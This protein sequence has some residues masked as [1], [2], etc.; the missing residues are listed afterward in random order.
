MTLKRGEVMGLWVW[1]AV[2]WLILAWV[3][4]DFWWFRP[5]LR[6]LR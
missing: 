1:I 4:K 2:V 6:E 3:F 5:F